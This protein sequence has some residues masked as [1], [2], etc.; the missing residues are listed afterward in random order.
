M[1]QILDDSGFEGG[2]A[3]LRKRTTFDVS[4]DLLGDLARIVSQVAGSGDAAA[5][6][7]DDAERLR[8]LVRSSDAEI[9]VGEDDLPRSVDLTLDFGGD[10]PDELVD[11]L[12]PYAAATLELHLELEAIDVD[13]EVDAPAVSG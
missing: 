12:G 3:A 1:V 9:V 6:S 2:F 4:L 8:S 11:A 13:L 5:P 10:V 7:G